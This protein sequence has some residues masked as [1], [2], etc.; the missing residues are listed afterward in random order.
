MN[1][2]ME[3]INK[4]LCFR[5]THPIA[6]LI[7]LKIETYLSDHDYSKTRYDSFASWCLKFQLPTENKYNRFIKYQQDHA[8]YKAEFNVFSDLKYLFYIDYYLHIQYYNYCKRLY[9][10]PIENL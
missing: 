2:P 8:S 10:M 1:L 3:L 7:K 4:I 9:H 5:P 6:K